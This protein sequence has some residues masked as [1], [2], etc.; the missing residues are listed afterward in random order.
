MLNKNTF[1]IPID[2]GGTLIVKFRSKR[3]EEERDCGV[4]V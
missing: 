2:K 4:C 3:L 1:T